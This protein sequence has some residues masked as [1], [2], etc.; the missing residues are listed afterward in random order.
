ME[1]AIKKYWPI[2]VLPTL[3]AFIIGFIIPFLQGVYLAFCQFT[4]VRD[5]TF[6]GISN[7][8]SALRDTTFTHAFWYNC[9]FVVVSTLAINVGGLAVALILTKAIRGTNAFRTVFFMPNLIGG[10][11]LGYIWQILLNCA[12]TL[13]ERP[14]LQLDPTAGFWGLVILMCWQ[15]IGYMM[16]IYIA[17]LQSI[18]GDVME[19]A[20]I[21][22]ATGPQRLFKVTIPMMMP[23]ITI[24]TFLSMVN[25]F[26]LFDQNLSLTAGEPA[27]MSELLALNIY[28]TFYGRTGWEGVGQ[29]KAVLFFI[30]VVVLGLLQLRLTRSKEVQQ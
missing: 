22:G 9:A 3:A 23:S 7:F 14:L 24:C 5:A 29:A 6:I 30:L 27:K 15:Q 16:I 2:F 26:K 8:I 13:L 28:N 4:T 12:L 11:V 19:A 10:I 20:A 18:P 1:K 21:D 25:G 17:G